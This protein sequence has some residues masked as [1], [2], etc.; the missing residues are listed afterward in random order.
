MTRAR[1]LEVGPISADRQ[2]DDSGWIV[3]AYEDRGALQI[4][5]ALIRDRD[6]HALAAI[7]TLMAAE[8]QKKRPATRRR[9]KR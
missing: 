2:D 8:S 4:S 5:G 7:A 1:R 6:V 9:A 3:H